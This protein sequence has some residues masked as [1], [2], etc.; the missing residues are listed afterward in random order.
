MDKK[1]TSFVCDS[2]S[3]IDQHT[4]LSNI[5]YEGAQGVLLDIDYGSYPFV[6][7]SSTSYGGIFTGAGAPRGKIDEV[8]GITKA[9]TTRVG[10]G[11]FPTE[12]VT[13]LG[14]KI[15][16]IGGEFGA[17]TGSKRRCGWLDLPL[18]K[19][20][21]K[22]SCIS[23]IA[24]TKLD[25]LSEVDEL[26]VCKAYKYEGK[27][28]DIAYPGIDLSQVEPIFETFTPFTDKFDGSELSDELDTF[29]KLKKVLKFQLELLL[30]GT[31]EIRYNLEKV[32]L[33][34]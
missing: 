17:T 3:I 25:V 12:L 27:T 24:L 2:F 8:I 31:K 11:P 32:F 28:I 22:S 14:E 19:Y 1:L 20:S 18:L 4:T 7:S 10:E 34:I 15:Q 21:I 9:Y 26:K 29:H 13:P 23:S 16:Q 5:L 6:T 33:N 30:S